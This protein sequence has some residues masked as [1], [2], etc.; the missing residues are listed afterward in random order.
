[1]SVFSLADAGEMDDD[2]ASADTVI[3][4]TSGSEDEAP[5]APVIVLSSD[6]EDDRM[7]EAEEAGP[8][9][10]G[11]VQVINSKPF[12]PMTIEP[13]LI[14]LKIKHMVSLLRHKIFWPSSVTTRGWA[15]RLS[16]QLGQCLHLLHV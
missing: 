13:F 14:H 8:T 7:Q 4:V 10:A 16:P 3:I 15:I 6:S 12:I 11:F 2:A 1:M 5:E 9:Y